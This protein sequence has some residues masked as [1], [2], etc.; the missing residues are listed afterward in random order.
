MYG[1]IKVIKRVYKL[2]Q[3]L[4]GHVMRAYLK[5]ALVTAYCFAMTVLSVIVALHIT[6]V[7]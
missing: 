3:S 1:E 7:V 5:M 2:Q 6:G 4:G